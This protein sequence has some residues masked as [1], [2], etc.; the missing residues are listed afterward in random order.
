GAAY[1][2]SPNSQCKRTAGLAD[3]GALVG[4]SVRIS[5]QSINAFVNP[6]L[7][8]DGK[9]ARQLQGYTDKPGDAQLGY[10]VPNLLIEY[11][12]RNTHVPVGPW[13]GVNTNQN[14]VYRECFIEEVARAPGPH[15]L[16][17]HR[18]R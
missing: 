13:R 15:A 11:A 12:M 17:F 10:S 1:V 5:G 14:A 7:V 16:E 18:A 3:K 6:A 4:L 9:D 2:Y 8:A